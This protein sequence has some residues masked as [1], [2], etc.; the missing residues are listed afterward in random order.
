MTNTRFIVELTLHDHPHETDVI[1]RFQ[2]LERVMQR[3][4][5]I[6]G[7]IE[8]YPPPNPE[9]MPILRNFDRIQK[10]LKYLKNNE[11]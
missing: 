2:P 9:T 7:R 3:D 4:Y 11:Q 5:F 8:N 1:Y 10:F 6:Y